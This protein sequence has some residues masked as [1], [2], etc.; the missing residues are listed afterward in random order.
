L[1]LKD[2][3]CFVSSASMGCTTALA[4]LPHTEAIVTATS[5][6][7]KHACQRNRNACYAA[8]GG[9]TPENLTSNADHA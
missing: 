7:H 3:I 4:S 1:E 9:V 8:A 2:V 5:A 6:A